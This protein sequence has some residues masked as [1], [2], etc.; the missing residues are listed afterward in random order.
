MK[1]LRTFGWGEKKLLAAGLTTVGK[2][3]DVKRCW[4]LKVNTKPVRVSGLDGAVFPNI[5]HFTYQV[6][7]VSY[8]GSRY[9]GL[10]PNFPRKGGTLTVCY[11][12]HDPAQYAVNI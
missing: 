8:Q 1:L 12:E 2:V 3:T 10:N 11:D 9:V 5:I 7:G 6:D 4:W